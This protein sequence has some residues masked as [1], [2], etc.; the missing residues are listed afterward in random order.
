MT[1]KSQMPSQAFVYILTM[2]IIGLLLILGVKWIGNI[3][4]EMRIAE[5]ILFKKDMEESFITGYNDQNAF[6]IEVSKEIEK[7]CFMEPGKYSELVPL[8]REG[9]SYEPMAC[10]DWKDGTAAVVLIPPTDVSI[11]TMDIE[12][13]SE[14]H[15][16]C[17]NNT[18]KRKLE[19]VMIGLGNR[20]R[21][22]QG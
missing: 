18:K 15:Y 12:V 21:V 16:L 19:L 8:C 17:F 14:H 9:P 11:D 7:I 2:I 1:K 10:D 22:S 5:L 6:E 4:E 3:L 13:D 20:T